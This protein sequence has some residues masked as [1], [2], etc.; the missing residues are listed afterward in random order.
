MID[1]VPLRD[2]AE[3]HGPERAFLSIYL[4]GPD[5]ASGLEH[6]FKTIRALLVDEP[7]ELAHFEESLRLA[8]P[9]LADFPKD[10]EALAVFA[11]WAND[12]A[13]AYPLPVAV[14]DRVWVGDAPYIRPIAELRDEYE[15]FALALVDSTAARLYVVSSAEAEEEGR[16]RGDVKNRVKVGGWSQKRYARRRDKQLEQY[17]EEVGEALAELDRE[18]PYA[19][20]VVLGA[21]ESVRAVVERLPPALADKLAGTRAVPT[22]GTE[23]E[24]L[25]AAFAVY[26]E[27]ERAAERRLWDE[28]R[29][30]LFHDGLAVSG[31]TRVLEAVEQARVEAILLDREATFGGTK[32]RACAHVVHGTPRTCQRCGSADVFEVDLV[33]ALVERA[34]RTGADVDFTDP[35]DAL[36]EVGHVAAL[37]RY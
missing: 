35:F 6:R 28:I 13:R 34:E 10:A 16:V 12:F 3:M 19:R 24:T 1:A 18:R 22:G 27:G 36:T 20:L 30:Q 14:E 33:E 15:D 29:E 21:D 31:A 23:E 2:L 37:L 26:F 8:E 11:C 17:A 7:D 25:E 32:C 5:A 9:L 4:S